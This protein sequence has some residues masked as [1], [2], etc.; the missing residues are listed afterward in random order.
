[1]QSSVIVA[2]DFDT[3]AEALA[4]AGQLDPQLCRLKVGSTLFTQSGPAIL[5]ALQEL[6]F[7]VFLDLKFHD[8][9]QQVAGACKQAAKLG[10]WMVTVH[11]AGGLDMLRA[12]RAALEGFSGRKPLIVGVTILTSLSSEDLSQLGYAC[13][14]IEIVERYAK[15]AESAGLDGVVC[16]AAEAKIVRE[17]SRKDF[18]LVTPGIRLA[19]DNNDDQKR[20]MTPRKAF[21]FG[22]NYIVVGRSITHNP[23]PLEALKKIIAEFSR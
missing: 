20:V 11:C 4:L 21:E 6:G 18:L 8:I 23:K 13:G 1:M 3:Q 10:V 5:N 7:D 19:T 17:S 12:A 16:S 14:L 2:L 22:S 15:L 9:P